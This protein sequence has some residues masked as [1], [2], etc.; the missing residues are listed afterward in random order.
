MLWSRHSSASPLALPAS[1]ILGESQPQPLPYVGIW[2]ILLATHKKKS[3]HPRG[4]SQRALLTLL[5]TFTMFIIFCSLYMES[6]PS[7]A[8][9]MAQES[10]R[11]SI[12]QAGQSV[13]ATPNTVNYSM[14]WR[15]GCRSHLL[16]AVQPRTK[17]P[18]QIHNGF[19][20]EELWVFSLLV[21]KAEGDALTQNPFSCK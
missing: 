13:V 7:N 4:T 1:P 17:L 9:L 19:T 18:A 14:L 16:P 21:Q 20:S 10:H 15:L 11:S 6:F 8:T 2:L 5:P 12:H 3:V